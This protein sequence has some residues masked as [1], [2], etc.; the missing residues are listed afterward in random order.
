MDL[1]TSLLVAC[2]ANS[3]K[4]IEVVQFLLSYGATLKLEQRWQGKSALLCAVQSGL[5]ELTK[6][7]LD[8][9]NLKINT[10]VSADKGW[11]ALIVAAHYGRIGLIQELID[12]G[13][14]SQTLSFLTNLFRLF[15]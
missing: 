1:S 3:D 5:Y 14:F 11:N 15:H 2:C 7:L 8:N 6:G 9:P 13:K 4:N 10:E 12:R